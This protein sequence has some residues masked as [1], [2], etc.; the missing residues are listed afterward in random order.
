MKESLTQGHPQVEDQDAESNLNSRAGRRLGVEEL[1]RAHASYVAAFLARLG[2]P[3]SEV[4]DLVQEVFLVVHR[5]GGFEVGVAQPKTW[6]GAIAVRVASSRRRSH[7]RSREHTNDE[8]L[9]A[10]VSPNATPDERLQARQSLSRV[11]QALD[12]L[13]LDHR[14]AFVLYEVEGQSCQDIATSLELPVGTVYSRLHHARK[15]FAEAYAS[16][17][18]AETEDGSHAPAKAVL[19]SA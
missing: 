17:V 16:L 1:F 19:G 18:A 6:L 10:A 14:A 3:A 9:Q 5:K 7:R 4:D 12:H 15:R 11:Q 8:V 13:D 2:M